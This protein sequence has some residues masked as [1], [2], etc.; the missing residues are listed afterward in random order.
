M[1]LADCPRKFHY[2]YRRGLVP[3]DGPV[4]M[5]SG[6]LFHAGMAAGYRALQAGFPE[7]CWVQAALNEVRKKNPVDRDGAPLGLSEENTLAVCDMI[8]YFNQYGRPNDSWDEI[9]AVEEPCTFEINGYSIR[10]T[11]DLLVRSKGELLVI[12]HKSSGDITQDM[13]HLPLDLQTHLY[14][15]GT[16]KRLGRPIEFVHS[17]TRRFDFSGSMRV[18]PPGWERHDGTRPYLLTAG[19]KVATRSSDPNDYLRRVRTPLT[20][21]QLQAF[22]K[23]LLAKL[24]MLTFMDVTN[25]F[26]RHD[27]K[28]AMGCGGC[29][30]Y[31][32]CT[33]EADGH[34]A[35]ASL[36]DVLF[37]NTTQAPAITGKRFG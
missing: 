31:S 7:E 16:W 29:S 30:Y 25:N 35:N 1:T 10:I 21:N 28:G 26:P 24:Q 36:L 32:L 18:G 8:E 15:Y 37:R 33:T 11:L 13:S 14:Y 19:G 22:E 3:Q 12:D 34:E 6:T 9:V 5:N 4:A 23:E 17:Y 2:R 27:K 20:L